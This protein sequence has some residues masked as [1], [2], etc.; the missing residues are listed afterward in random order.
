MVLVQPI[1]C[2]VMVVGCQ[3]AHPV[4]GIVVSKELLDE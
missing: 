2:L 1:N 3:E 4:Y